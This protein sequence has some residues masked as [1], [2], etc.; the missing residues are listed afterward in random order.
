M[1]ERR[2]IDA[3]QEIAQRYPAGHGPCGPA[4]ADIASYLQE[5]G[6]P[7]A[8]QTKGNVSPSTDPRTWDA[9]NCK[10][11]KDHGFL[12]HMW[13][14]VNGHIVDAAAAQ[15]GE[16]RLLIL[17]PGDSRQAWYHAI[18]ERDEN[19]AEGPISVSWGPF[20]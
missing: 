2:H 15:F 14:S 19:Y 13:V 17:T 10:I 12:P 11:L 4:S 5:N 9:V 20:G 1:F 18:P 8:R 16:E 7:E 3:M 6:F